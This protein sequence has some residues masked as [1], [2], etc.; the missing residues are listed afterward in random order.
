[1]NRKIR[2]KY[3]Y[4]MFVGFQRIE[5]AIACT[6]INSAWTEGVRYC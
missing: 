6:L 3:M 5:R 4:H 2:N 1:M